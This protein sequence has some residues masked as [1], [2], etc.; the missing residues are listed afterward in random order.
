M[1]KPPTLD[2]SSGH[3]LRGKGLSPTSS[4]MLS[5]ESAYLS[6]S[7]PPLLMLSLSLS[8]FHVNKMWGAWVAQFVKHL[9]SAQVM[10]PGSGDQVPHQAL[11]SMASLLL[12]LSLSLLLLV[13]S[14]PP[15]LSFSLKQTKKQTK[16]NKQTNKICLKTKQNKKIS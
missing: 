15:S 3:D 1:I 2:F 14:L 8:L 16:T 6:P 13:L 5:M 12:P 7:A 4:S 11:C 9:P 10:I